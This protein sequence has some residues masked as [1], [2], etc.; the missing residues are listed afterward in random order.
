M[1]TD[2]ADQQRAKEKLNQINSSLQYWLT[3]PA[4]SIR[5]PEQRQKATLLARSLLVILLLY[6]VPEIFRFLSPNNGPSA[7]LYGSIPLLFAYILSRTRYYRFGI[8]MTMAFFTMLPAG[9]LLFRIIEPAE[10]ITAVIWIIPTLIFGSLLLSRRQTNILI[11][12]NVLAVLVIPFLIPAVTFRTLFYP[13]GFVLV[14]IIL[15]NVVINTRQEYLDQIKS[16]ADELARSE[17]QFR[18]LVEHSH[19][20]VLQASSDFR[21]AYVNDELCRILGYSRAELTDRDFR[22]LLDEE[23][24]EMVID[25]YRR[26]QAG[27]DVPSRYEFGIIRKDDQRRQVE[28]SAAT[29]KDVDGRSQ[30]IALLLDI[31]E[32]KQMENALR[33][34]EAL[35]QSLVNS[36]PQNIFRRDANGRFTFANQHFCDLHGLPLAEIIGKTDFDLHPP[37]MAKKYWTDD[38]RVMETGQPYEAIE[39]HQRKN[40]PI[41]Y[42]QVIKTPTYDAAGRLTGI[43]GIFWDITEVKRAQEALQRA[44]NELEKRVEERTQE[45][46]A[47]NAQL[48]ELDRLK[49]KF[50]EDMSHELRTPLANL[51]LYLDLLEMGKAEKRSTYLTALRLAASRVTH[52]SEDVLAMIRLE[53]F[54]EDVQFGSL[55]L[56][57]LTAGVVRQHQIQ[58]RSAGLEL[59]FSPGVSLPLI[60][61]EA[62][63]LNHCLTN[64][65]HNSIRY[66]SEGNIEIRTYLDDERN[67]VCLQVADTGTG[68]EPEDLPFVF[69]RFYRGRQVGQS[70]IPGSGLGL[71]LVKQIAELHGGSV[72][73]ENRA[74]KGSIFRCWFPPANRQAAGQKP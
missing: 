43:Q 3:R 41:E 31:T 74:E 42:A 10:T 16:Q 28:M 6:L 22:K 68:I 11:A 64:L 35:Y 73:A 66:T 60:L 14:V 57:E 20:G 17:A 63:Q 55:D 69:D 48:K 23:S 7:L 52:I 70:S 54:K 13:L 53:L 65:L 36:L 26:R 47:A 34:S 38:L 32:R 12:V 8:F 61:G 30:T 18:S 9:S 71:A 50:I 1:E 24:Q 37:E 21:L 29:F 15:L 58:A 33:D 40:A 59:T 51:N 44:H 72:A 27:E 49:N 62:S 56:N 46:A 5:Q 45:L 25:F 2:I 19:A 39:V 4:S 67:Q